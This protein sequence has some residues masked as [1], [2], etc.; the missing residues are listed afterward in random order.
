MRQSFCLVMFQYTILTHPQECGNSMTHAIQTSAMCCK[1]INLLL[2]QSEYDENEKMLILPSLHQS[3]WVW[4][5]EIFGL[6][7][8]NYTV[9]QRQKQTTINKKLN[10]GA[11]HSKTL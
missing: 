3:S 2:F 10:W 1:C 4:F 7:N 6:I 11:M 8:L 5:I 9:I